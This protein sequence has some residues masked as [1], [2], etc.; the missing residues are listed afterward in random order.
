MYRGGYKV[1]Q[2][3]SLESLPK[4]T[5]VLI[6]IFY[7]NYILSIAALVAGDGELFSKKKNSFGPNISIRK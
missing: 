4:K 6:S 2:G 7:K 5:N 1:Q 3:S